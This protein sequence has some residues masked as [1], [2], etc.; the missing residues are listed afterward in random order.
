MNMRIQRRKKL[1]RLER[2]RIK[3][4]AERKRLRIA[5]KNEVLLAIHKIKVKQGR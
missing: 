2:K 3:R 4:N 1:A 5:N